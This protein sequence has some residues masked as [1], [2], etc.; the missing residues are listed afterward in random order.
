MWEV[1]LSDDSISQMNEDI[2]LWRKIRDKCK[3]NGLH[4]TSLK[5]NGEEIDPRGKSVFIISDIVGTASQGIIRARIGLGTFRSN[6][7]AS[8]QWK[9]IKGDP[10]FGDH[11]QIV[12][13][14]EAR[15]YN[16]LAIE[17]VLS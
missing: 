1:T 9:T 13:A 6:D 12:P 3:Q 15:Q 8:I 10:E 7:K 14:S 5:W 4:V 2:T 16:E 17:R 11:S